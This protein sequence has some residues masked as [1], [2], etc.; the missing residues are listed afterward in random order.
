M[1]IAI[2]ALLLA[3]LGSQWIVARVNAKLM[4]N[5]AAMLSHDVAEAMK[6]ILESLP[7]VLTE[8]KD[9]M[10]PQEP[11][12]P[13]AQMFMQHLSQSLGGNQVPG[14]ENIKEII[15]REDDGT[16]SKP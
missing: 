14:L 1:E 15:P 12:N 13:L 10:I 9:Q 4:Q 8:F 5:T 11:V 7:E 16:F 3:G 2:L 6:S